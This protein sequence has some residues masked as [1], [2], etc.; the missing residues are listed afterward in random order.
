M[1]HLFGPLPMFLHLQKECNERFVELLEEN[2]KESRKLSANLCR[3]LR[4]KHV[5]PALRSLQAFLASLPQNGLC[6]GTVPVC[7]ALFTR[8]PLQNSRRWPP[9]RVRMP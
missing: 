8:C 9:S 2:S 6:A 5:L 1:P 3:D 4:K 7:R